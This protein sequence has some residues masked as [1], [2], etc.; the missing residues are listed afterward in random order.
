MVENTPGTYMQMSTEALLA[1]QQRLQA[2]YDG[3]QAR[4]LSLNMARGK[5]A[6]NQLDLA[7]P[8]LVALPESERPLDA[9]G[10]D[11][12]N[13]GQLLGIDEAR[14]LMADLLEVPKEN[15][16]IGNNASLTL[17]YDTVVRG[18]LFGQGGNTAQIYQGRRGPLR[19]LCPSPGY[20]RHFSIS[21]SLGFDNIAIPMSADGPDMDMVEQL[22]NNDPTVKGIWCVPKYANPSGITYS[23]A[24]VRRFANLSPAAADFR[25]Y[26]DNAYAVHDLYPGRGDQ[27]LNLMQAC[28]EA[29]NPDIWFMF[30][31]TSKISFAGSGIS[32]MATS[33]FNL[34]EVEKHIGVQTIGPDKV[35]QLRH[36]R[37]LEELGGGPGQGL[38]GVYQQMQRQAE[39]L[40]PKFEMV[41]A[42]LRR[43]LEGL[44]IAEWTSPNGG[45]FIS[46]AGLPGTAKRTVA[47]AKAAGVVLTDA[48]ATWPGGNDPA[49]SNIRIAPS[50]PSLNELELASELL[51]V[52]LRLAAVERLLADLSGEA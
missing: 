18:L 22:V 9:S 33:L 48:G 25:I 5:P 50:Y 24:V 3:Y 30:T 2:A 40:A 8:L 23:D 47:L 7:Q 41:D 10:E 21:A 12:R 15:V 42:V 1:E 11:T 31:S 37:W 29:Q 26:W 52:C 32:A 20:D 35:N 4:N 43:D 28:A 14:Q 44:G 36:V 13:Y 46:L 16:L 49:D 27:L 6:P 45:Y 19:F 34:A 39:L 17:M 38:A 51:T